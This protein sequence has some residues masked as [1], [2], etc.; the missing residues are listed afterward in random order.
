MKLNENE[1]NFSVPLEIIKASEIEPKEVKWLWYPYIPFGKV[2][3]L[4]GDPGDGKSKLML[5]IA[6]LLSKGEPIP[7]TETEENEPMTIIYQTTEDDADDTVVPRF[8]S[9]GGD[10]ENL[11]FIKED[12]KT[13]SF[14]DNRIR[15][16]IEKYNA[17]LLILDPLSSYIQNHANYQGSAIGLGGSIAMNFDT[18][19]GEHGQAQN[20]KQAVNE[21]GEKLY[22]DSQGRRANT[23]AG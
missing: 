11:I 19:F 10:G 4:Q 13:L 16:A 7:F 5:S 20:N 14:G 3:L 6:A 8:N 15:E 17:K 12:E 2:T 23:N 9:A 1:M 18:P 21:Q 22:I